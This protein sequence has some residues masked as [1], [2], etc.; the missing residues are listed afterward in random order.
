MGEDL[1]WCAFQEG[2]DLSKGLPVSAS[3]DDVI[4]LP[5][6]GVDTLTEKQAVVDLEKWHHRVNEM[7]TEA[8]NREDESKSGK[9]RFLSNFLGRRISNQSTGSAISKVSSG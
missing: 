4:K 1:S 8:H 5:L 7:R 2:V 6:L 3:V 9:P